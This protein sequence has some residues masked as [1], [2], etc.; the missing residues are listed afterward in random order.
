MDRGSTIRKMNENHK[1]ARRIIEEILEIIQSNPF[2]KKNFFHT[3]HL[4]VINWGSEVRD[5]RPRQQT[6]IVQCFLLYYVLWRLVVRRTWLSNLML[7][8]NCDVD[9]EE[10]RDSFSPWKD[11]S[12]MNRVNIFKSAPQCQAQRCPSK[13][14]RS[15]VIE[16]KDFRLPCH[17]SV[18][19]GAWCSQPWSHFSIKQIIKLSRL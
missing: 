6:R 8:G 11:A 13:P 7:Q 19:L 12:L 9:G 16:K 18:H 3:F 4:Q 14:S 17:C 2:F 1:N 10:G 15:S 5:Y